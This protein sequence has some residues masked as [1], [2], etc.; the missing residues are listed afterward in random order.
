MEEYWPMM[1][2]T[3]EKKMQMLLFKLHLQEKD[4]ERVVQAVCSQKLLLVPAHQIFG[5]YIKLVKKPV[6]D[7]CGICKQPKYG[8]LI[9][10]TV[11]I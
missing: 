1:N 8:T 10:S 5:A 9:P 4:E 11:L 6:S 2:Q 3:P 7:K